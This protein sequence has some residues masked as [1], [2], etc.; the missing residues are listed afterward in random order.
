MLKNLFKNLSV[1]KAAIKNATSS[2]PSR[3]EIARVEAENRKAF[4]MAGVDINKKGRLTSDE[5]ARLNAAL[6]K[7]RAG[8]KNGPTQKD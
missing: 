4:R 8:D 1:R 7:M 5:V 3:Q 6:T 2:R